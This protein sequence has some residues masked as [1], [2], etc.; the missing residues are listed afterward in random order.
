ML[1]VVRFGKTVKIFIFRCQNIIV[2]KELVS[3][4]LRRRKLPQIS[5]LNADPDSGSGDPESNP[6]SL[7]ERA[8]PQRAILNFSPGPQG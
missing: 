6:F 7:S 5:E 4:N 2:K 3:V 1:L 8:G